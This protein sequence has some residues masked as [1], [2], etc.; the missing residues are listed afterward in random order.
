M[1]KLFVLLLALTLAAGAF[2]QTIA[3]TASGGVT[4]YDQDGNTQ[5]ARDGSGYDTL[6][7]KGADK[8]GKWGFS[9][10][11]GNWPAAN[12]T[13]T[14][15]DWS[16]WYSSDFVKIILGQVRNGDFR[17]TLTEGVLGNY[18]GAT[19]RFFNGAA[20]GVIAESTSLGP[21]TLG[22]GLYT[23]ETAMAAAD[24]IEKAGF[25]V[26]YKTDTLTA[27][28]LVNLGITTTAPAT[29][30]FVN[31]AVSFTGVKDLQV[32]GTVK[33]NLDDAIYDFGIG[34][35]YTMDKLYAFVEFDG[36]YATALD[37]EAVVRADYKVLDN[38]TA[39]AEFD[40]ATDAA[41]A[42][43]EYVGYVKGI[44]DFGNGL[45]ASVKVGYADTGVLYAVG[46]G[47][48]VSF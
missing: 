9:T 1:K 3:L 35:Y 41:V 11:Y 2:A 4:L 7:F 34:G 44:Y 47:Y 37:F 26:K 5:F 29:A 8:D 21:L 38:V 33:A 25:G 30:N 27:L 12:G 32:V 17:M 16:A 31:A 48:S 39:R 28:A 19:Q 45:D 22:L 18:A 46:L 23:P 15:R 43:N 42:G 36:E 20:Y 24:A 13:A 6:S 14:I 40:Y 10:T